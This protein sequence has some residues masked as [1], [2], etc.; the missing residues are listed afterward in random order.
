MANL[1]S[2][3]GAALTGTAPPVEAPHA[4][5]DNEIVKVGDKWIWRRGQSTGRKNLFLDELKDV[6][7]F[8]LVDHILSSRSRLASHPLKVGKLCIAF[9]HGVFLHTVRTD[10]SPMVPS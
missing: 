9:T 3:P 10:N 5:V 2:M 6:Q 4:D 8:K 1:D 7:K